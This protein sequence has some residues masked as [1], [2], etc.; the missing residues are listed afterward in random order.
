MSASLGLALG[1]LPTQAKL[2]QL[3]TLFICGDSYSD[4]G[5]SGLLTQ[6]IPPYISGSP[7]SPYA[8]GRASNGRVAVE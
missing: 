4:A 1:P 5:N 7:P 8:N 6:G 2:A 3:D